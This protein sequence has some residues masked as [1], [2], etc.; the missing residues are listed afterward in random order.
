MI[1]KEIFLS[2]RN[3]L[4]FTY[5]G[6]SFYTKQIWCHVVGSSHPVFFSH[7]LIHHI[8]HSTVYVST[9]ISCTLYSHFLFLTKH[10]FCT[11]TVWK[12][13]VAGRLL[14]VSVCFFSASLCV[15]YRGPFVIKN[16]HVAP[17]VYISGR[18]QHSGA[19]RGSWAE[20]CWVRGST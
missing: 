4:R 3:T 2:L 1:N 20:Y 8:I 12:K 5:K 10:G 9:N 15:L 11:E 19:W 7:F 14:Q 18:T 17:L 16:I 13:T 6:N